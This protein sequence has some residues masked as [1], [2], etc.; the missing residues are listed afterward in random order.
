MV[1]PSGLTPENFYS[2]TD[3]W[4]E[5]LLSGGGGS[6]GTTYDFEDSLDGWTLASGSSGWNIV[7]GQ[8]VGPVVG[9]PVSLLYHSIESLADESI[10][11]SADLTT[12][13]VDGAAGIYLSD[14]TGK[15]YGLVV[16]KNVFVGSG[17]SGLCIIF[18]ETFSAYGGSNAVAPDG[19]AIPVP[20]GEGI[21]GRASMT[22]YPGA[23]PRVVAKW[24]DVVIYD[25]TPTAYSA[26][27]LIGD[28]PWLGGVVS[29]NGLMGDVKIDNFSVE[30]N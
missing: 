29:Y 7:N 1:G 22:V 15:G 20:Y 19:A 17:I 26:T 25:V 14:L 3:H 28:K 10:T 23:I 6:E 12:P 13:T 16:G 11:V 24:N 30:V 2:I 4:Y 5:T 27:R 18:T 9:G 8:L 21:T